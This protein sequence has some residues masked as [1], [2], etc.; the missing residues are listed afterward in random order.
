MCPGKPVMDPPRANC[1]LRADSPMVE[2]ALQTCMWP[3]GGRSFGVRGLESL[4]AGGKRVLGP[5][6]R[7]LA[8]NRYFF[9]WSGLGFKKKFRK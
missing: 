1:F 5:K 6:V 3:D 2:S 8:R 4:E 7:M 9:F